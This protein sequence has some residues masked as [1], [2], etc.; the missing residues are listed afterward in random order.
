MTLGVPLLLL[1]RKLGD[2]P[3]RKTVLYPPTFA[4]AR[5]EAKRVSGGVSSCWGGSAVDARTGFATFLKC[6]AWANSCC[7]GL[8][9]GW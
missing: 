1:I 2:A 5:S 3:G 7:P 4:Q 9:H 6:K 8:K